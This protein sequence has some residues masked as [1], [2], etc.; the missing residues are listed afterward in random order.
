VVGDLSLLQRDYGITVQEESA[1]AR[2]ERADA[3]YQE[4]LDEHRWRG[5]GG[6]DLD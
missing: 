1:A 2:T 6:I 5:L 4:Q 3:F